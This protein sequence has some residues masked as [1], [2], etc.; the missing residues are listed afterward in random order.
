VHFRSH[1]DEEAVARARRLAVAMEVQG[2]RFRAA[3]GQDGTAGTAGT[4][5]MNR[6]QVLGFEVASPDARAQG[7]GGAAQTCGRRFRGFADGLDFLRGFAC[8]E[9]AEDGAKAFLVEAGE[10]PGAEARE[11][12]FRAFRGEGIAA[13]EDKEALRGERLEPQEGF[14]LA[15]R[16]DFADSGRRDF[17]ARDDSVPEGRRGFRKEQPFAETPV[18]GRTFQQ[19]TGMRMVDARQIKEVGPWIRPEKAEK[20]AGGVDRLERSCG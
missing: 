10:E 3:G 20:R 6:V 14:E 7:G 16:E 17:R 4:T 1:I 5:L 8:A 9:R 11:P 18:R 19:E 2:E 13:P 15:G 12:W